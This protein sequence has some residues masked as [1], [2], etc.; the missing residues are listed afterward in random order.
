MSSIKISNLNISDWQ[1]NSESS[2]LL[3]QVTDK[4]LKKVLGGDYSHY[5]H[6]PY[7]AVYKA[8]GYAKKYLDKYL[9]DL[10]DYKH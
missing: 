4:E 5:H 1:D 2:S 6:Y 9:P 3:Q 10:D 7:Y 8:L